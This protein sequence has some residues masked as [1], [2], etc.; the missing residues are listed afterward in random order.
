MREILVV[1]K[2]NDYSSQTEQIKESR[3]ESNPPVQKQSDKHPIPEHLSFCH[4]SC[5]PI[6]QASPSIKFISKQKTS[7]SVAVGKIPGGE[8]V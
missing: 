3:Y 4:T 7:L 8:L 2:S 5:R 6:I 1:V